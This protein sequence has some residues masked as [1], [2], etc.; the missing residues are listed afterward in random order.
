MPGLI[1]LSRQ[2]KNLETPREAKGSAKTNRKTVSHR[3]WC[4]MNY[5]LSIILAYPVFNAEYARITPESVEFYCKAKRISGWTTTKLAIKSL[6]IRDAK[7]AT[8][9]TLPM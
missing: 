1:C 3:S 2:G 8:T 9:P 5:H 7:Q 6:N 4:L